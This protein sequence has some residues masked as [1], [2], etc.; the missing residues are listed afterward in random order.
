[1]KKKKNVYEA[2]PL[3]DL[4]SQDDIKEDNEVNLLWRV[5]TSHQRGF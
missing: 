4:D 1:M 3:I 5:K 2:P